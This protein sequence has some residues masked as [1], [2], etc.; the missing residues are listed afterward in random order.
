M[1][2]FARREFRDEIAKLHP[3]ALALLFDVYGY[4]S[5]QNKD[6]IVT[7]IYREDGI[8]SLFRAF[9]FIIP[10]KSLFTIDMRACEIVSRLVNCKYAYD[11][12][13]SKFLVLLFGDD[14][15]RGEHYDHVH[16]QVHPNTKLMLNSKDMYGYQEMKDFD[17][18]LG[19]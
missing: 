2:Y 19:E 4:C 5:Q 10:H 7:S 14:D 6:M 16:A 1:I 13:R 3:K 18:F 12:D 11:P 17:I 15:P 9:D 8:H